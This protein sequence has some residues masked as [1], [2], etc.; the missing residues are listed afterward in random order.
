MMTEQMQSEIAELNH[1]LEEIDDPRRSYAIVQE[2]IRAYRRHGHKVPEA[3][4]LIERR[5]AA[6][7]RTESQGR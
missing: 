2:R 7:C 6:E 4:S 3:L 5:L 1:R